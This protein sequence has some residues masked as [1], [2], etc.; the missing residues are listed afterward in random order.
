[1]FDLYK[2]GVDSGHFKDV[3]PKMA[4]LTILGACHWTYFWYRADKF[5]GPEQL[6]SQMLELFT[7]GFYIGRDTTEKDK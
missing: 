4:V 6:A 1:M 7:E 3:D 2:Q 5:P